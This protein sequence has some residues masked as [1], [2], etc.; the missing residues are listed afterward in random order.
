[1]NVTMT[2]EFKLD[3]LIDVWE[4]FDQFDVELHLLKKN[5]Q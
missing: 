1:M 3:L 4:T 5:M 2:L